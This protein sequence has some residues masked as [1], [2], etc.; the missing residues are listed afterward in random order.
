LILQEVAG[1]D[2][3]DMFGFALSSHAKYF[4]GDKWK[5]LKEHMDGIDWSG[6]EDLKAKVEEYSPQPKRRR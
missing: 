1:D 3:D 5:W 2:G 4:D 6:C